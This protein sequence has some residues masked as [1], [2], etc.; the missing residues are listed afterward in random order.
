[1]RINQFT[2]EIILNRIDF[3]F[4]HLHYPHSPN[5]IIKCRSLY[6][7]HH[8]NQRR[9][10]GN[11]KSSI[12]EHIILLL[13]GK[14]RIWGN[15]RQ[16][17]SCLISNLQNGDFS[18]LQIFVSFRGII[19][20]RIVSEWL[21]CRVSQHLFIRCNL[22]SRIQNTNN[23]IFGSLSICASSSISECSKSLPTCVT[24]EE[25]RRCDKI[26]ANSMKKQTSN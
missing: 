18:P 24:L 15:H 25:E 16:F 4:H 2:V 6:L 5:T 7:Q 8:C 20:F 21:P 13:Y 1:M 14:E 3:F 17:L 23:I 19:G 11:G 22:Y 10:F 26:N 12:F 9:E